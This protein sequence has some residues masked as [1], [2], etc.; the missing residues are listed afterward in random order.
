MSDAA[1][2]ESVVVCRVTNPPLELITSDKAFRPN[3]VT[4]RFARVIRIEP[5]NTV[6]DVGTGIGPLAI[7][8]AMEGAARVY[9]VDPVPLHCELARRNVAKYHLEDRVSVHQGRFFEPM[10]TDPA[11]QGVKADVI[12]ADVSGIAEGVS[13]ALGWYSD[14]VPT[15]G[16]DGT[17]Q[18]RTLLAAA[19]DF[20]R[21]GGTL[22]FPIAL[23]LSDGDRILAAAEELF[24]SVENAFDKG[25]FEFPLSPAEVGAIEAAYAHRV[26][27]FVKVQ[28]RADRAGTKTSFWRGKILVAKGPKRAAECR[29]VTAKS[30]RPAPL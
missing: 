12:I 5:G 6:F 14:E 10:E 17:D 30:L 18:I 13:Y 21:P 16:P 8:A 4:V 23:D 27:C 24:E 2:S 25:C 11:L 26:P 3:P 20:L 28:E 15:G 9:A 7:K 29:V 22:Y 19:A 1:I